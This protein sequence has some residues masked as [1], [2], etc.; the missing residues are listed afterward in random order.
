MD[1]EQLT[2]VLIIAMVFGAIAFI[3]KAAVDGLVRYK[4]LR[5]GITPETF[6][7]VM[8]AERAARRLASLKWGLLAMG[9]A[10][11]LLA[12]H[13]MALPVNSAAALACLFLGAGVALL[14]FYGVTRSRS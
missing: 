1:N 3:A 8:A 10:A 2:Q 4:A 7:D 13:R 9:Q 12:I 14:A 11:A 6:S 5:G